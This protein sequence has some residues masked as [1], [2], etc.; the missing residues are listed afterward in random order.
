[1]QSASVARDKSG[2]ALH[3]SEA[4]D[5][6]PQEG[7]ASL[8]VAWLVASAAVERDA[9]SMRAVDPLDLVDA[10]KDFLLLTEQGRV[11]VAALREGGATPEHHAKMRA[12]LDFLIGDYLEL[13][14][15]RD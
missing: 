1:M 11:Y 2:Y 4:D 15:G 3:V 8:A 7:D 14:A 12:T 5:D 10:L 13:E 6:E 9:R